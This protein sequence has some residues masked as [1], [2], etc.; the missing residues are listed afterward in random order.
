MNRRYSTEIVKALYE[1]SRIKGI[2]HAF[3]AREYNI[4]SVSYVSDLI[5]AY[6][7]TLTI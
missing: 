1:G 4:S 5:R 2:K 3:L 7:K 6:E